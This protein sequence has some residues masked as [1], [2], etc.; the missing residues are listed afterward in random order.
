[1]THIKSLAVGNGDMFYICH[2]S[3]SFTI[4]DCDL[5][6]DNADTIIADVKAAAKSKGI[7]RFICTHPDEDHFGGIERLD[8]AMPIVNFYVVKNQAVKD[9]D[10]TSF[11]HY[12]ALRDSEKA[13][14]IFKVA[15]ENG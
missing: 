8:A 9:E 13:F 1:M 6:Q 7:T 4:I 10:T 12:C 3:D 15:P 5:C 2:S 14:Y 11:A